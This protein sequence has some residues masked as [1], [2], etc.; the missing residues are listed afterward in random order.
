MKNN[1]RE[2]IKSAIE[3]NAVSFKDTASQTLYTKVASKLQE[4]YKTVAQN[5]MRPTNEADNRT[6]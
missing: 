4:Q 3:E 2:M 5:L 1:I 6:N